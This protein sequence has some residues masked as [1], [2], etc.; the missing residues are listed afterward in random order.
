[1][2]FLL[3]PEYGLLLPYL[4]LVQ[5]RRN[6]TSLKTKYLL[7]LLKSFLKSSRTNVQKHRLQA[8]PCTYTRQHKAIGSCFCITL[9]PGRDGL[10]T[11]TWSLPFADRHAPSGNLLSFKNTA[12]HIPES[13]FAPCGVPV[14]LRYSKIYIKKYVNMPEA[15][16]GGKWIIELVL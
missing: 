9:A 14:E 5:Q 8:Q 6:G 1:M 12:L 11:G 13:S 3:L 16:S 10:K 4:P 15:I 7:V 2:V